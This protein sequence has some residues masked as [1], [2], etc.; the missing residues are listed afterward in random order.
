MNESRS[1][2][3]MLAR[4]LAVYLAAIAV[5][6]LL[7]AISATQHVASSLESMGLPVSVGTRISMVG[8]DLVGMAGM[9]LPLIAFGFLVAFLVT[10]LLCRW[11]GRWR[12]A[13]YAL[14]GACALICIHVALNLAFDITPVAIARSTS[15]LMLQGLAGA[16]GGYVYAV[17]SPHIS[18]PSISAL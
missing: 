3:W 8:Q 9:F 17:F 7:A 15:G 10:A 5:T 11:W 13:L 6:Y 2:G 1:I 12:N 14:A 4:R 16:L 18:V